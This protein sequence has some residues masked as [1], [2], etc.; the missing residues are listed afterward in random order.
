LLSFLD[1]KK[2]LYMLMRIPVNSAT[3]SA[4]CRPVAE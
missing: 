1:F 4:P 2:A 3:E